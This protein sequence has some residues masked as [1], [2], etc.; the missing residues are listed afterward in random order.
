MLPLCCVLSGLAAVVCVVL[1]SQAEMSRPQALVD[2][3][4]DRILTR[5][6][7]ID[8]KYDEKVRAVLPRL[9]HPPATAYFPMFAPPPAGMLARAQG[10]GA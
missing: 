9:S 4:K 3:Y 10:P 1:I 5:D 7:T 6:G 2:S 8:L